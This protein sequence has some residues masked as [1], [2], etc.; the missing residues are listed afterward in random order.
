MANDNDNDDVP[1]SQKTE[2]AI[3]GAIILNNGL[4]IQAREHLRHEDFFITANRKVW[5]TMCKL[6]DRH[7][8]IDLITLHE[9]LDDDKILADIGGASKVSSYI[10]GVPITDSIQPYIDIVLEKSMRRRLTQLSHHLSNAAADL[11]HD[12]E[13]IFDK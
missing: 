5:L 4:M 3:L 10:D 9:Q 7:S 8:P 13:S 2:D 12:V 1:Y 6:Q 11:E